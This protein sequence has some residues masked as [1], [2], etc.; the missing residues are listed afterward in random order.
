MLISGWSGSPGEATPG[1][2]FHEDE[3]VNFVDN[4]VEL[5]SNGALIVRL[6]RPY[7]TRA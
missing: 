3:G 5:S 2:R 4:Q 1:A 6:L 7:G